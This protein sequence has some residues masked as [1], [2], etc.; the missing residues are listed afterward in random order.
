VSGGTPDVIWWWYAW[1]VGGR[2]F[3]AGY[4]CG[5]G[6]QF[7]YKTCKESSRRLLPLGEVGLPVRLSEVGEREAW[8]PEVEWDEEVWF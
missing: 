8:P 6:G 3:G 5:L 1:Y 2:G 4:T 7:S